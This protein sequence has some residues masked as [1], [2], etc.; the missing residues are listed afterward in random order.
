M[1]EFADRHGYAV[2][3]V[4]G[5]WDDI[6]NLIL[7]GWRGVAVAGDRSHIPANR[8]P[9]W[10]FLSEEERMQLREAL[11]RTGRTWEGLQRPPGGP[12]V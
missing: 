1:F 8:L 7:D 4:V 6:L 10:E 3:G 9:R 12:R 5:V 2:D 11:Q